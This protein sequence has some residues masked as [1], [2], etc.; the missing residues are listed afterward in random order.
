MSESTDYTREELLEFYVRWLENLIDL[1][2][3]RYLNDEISIIV[4]GNIKGR[5]RG[6]MKEEME[7]EDGN[8]QG[9]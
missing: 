6:I 8:R 3:R 9:E 5:R 7:D 1:L 4:K 2:C